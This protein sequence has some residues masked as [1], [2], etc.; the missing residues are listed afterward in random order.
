MAR[1]GKANIYLAHT[2][3]CLQM[4]GPP[5]V[6]NCD[7][8]LTLQALGCIVLPVLIIHNGPNHSPFSHSHALGAATAAG[9]G[10]VR[11]HEVPIIVMLTFVVVEGQVCMC[12]MAELVQ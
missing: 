3:S 6:V 2:L 12:R 5:R 8:G 11:R 4:A 9:G 1:H 10:D 7:M